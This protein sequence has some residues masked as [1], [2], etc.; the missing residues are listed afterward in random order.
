PELQPV[1]DKN[2]EQKQD[3]EGNPVLEEPPHT[4]M[5]YLAD[6]KYLLLSVLTPHKGNLY[7]KKYPDLKVK[8]RFFHKAYLVEGIVRFLDFI[9]VRGEHA[10]RFSYPAKLGMTKGRSY[11]RTLNAHYGSIK[12]TLEGE[13]I[14]PI[15]PTV[16]D[17]S[18]GGIAFCHP[19][20]IQQLPKDF[21]L[22]LALTFQKELPVKL[23]A[24]VR[25]H[26][27]VTKVIARNRVC[28]ISH[29]I[30]GTQFDIKD[31]TLEMRIGRIV[32]AMQLE[33]MSKM[34]KLC[35]PMDL[36]STLEFWN[37]RD[38]ERYGGRKKRASSLQ[39]KD[40]QEMKEEL[41]GVT[42]KR[43][44]DQAKAEEEERKQKQP[45]S[46]EE[47][48]KKLEARDKAKRLARK[49]ASKGILGGLMN[50]LGIDSDKNRRASD[51]RKAAKRVATN[52]RKGDRREG[53]DMSAQEK[54]RVEKQL[55][56]LK[57]KQ[58]QKG[59][60]AE[61]DTMLLERKINK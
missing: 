44:A 54:A 19:I 51:R 2:G 21:Q 27:P 23:N 16:Y 38:K 6:G 42:A 56:E 20:P 29:S 24:F 26:S 25:N 45:P 49:K 11:F 50:K 43:E 7:F 33:A 39:F 55:A 58:I 31:E 52:R 35:E 22:K 13:E 15:T 30:C 1:M 10:L 3:E 5:A 28:R 47:R 36:P 60:L 14:E 18:L 9:K 37:K 41:S 8:I 17:I 53:R 32:S 34:A 4:P 48:A 61:L 59:S 46:I 57:A 40:D 12:L